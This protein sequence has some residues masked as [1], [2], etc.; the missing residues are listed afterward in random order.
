MSARNICSVCECMNNVIDC[1][2]QNLHKI[3]PLNPSL[4]T[5]L[6]IQINLSYNLFTNKEVVAWLDQ[7]DHP[8]IVL[9][10]RHNLHCLTFDQDKY[11]VSCY[12]GF[13][14]FLTY[15]KSIFK[16]ER[17]NT[18]IFFVIGFFFLF[19][20]DNGFFIILQSHIFTDACSPK[21]TP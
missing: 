9:D 1:K 12:I 16:M 20:F 7:F 19:Y 14:I 5:N 2:E 4:Y 3:P 10:L 15:E 21:K 18:Y 6:F 17:I 11:Q 8:K 13:F